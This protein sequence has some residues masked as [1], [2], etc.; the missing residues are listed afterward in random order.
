M[1]NCTNSA[2]RYSEL[3]REIRYRWRLLK[4]IFSAFVVLLVHIAGAQSY[5]PPVGIPAPPFGIE[6]QLDDYYTRPNPWDAETPGWYYIDQYHPNASDNVTYGTPNAPRRTLPAIIPA[7]SVVEIHGDY[8]WAPTG[9]DVLQ[10]EGTAE[11]P[12]FVVGGPNARVLRKW[13]LK[14]SYTI[15]EQLEFTEQ[16]KITIVYP[17]HHIAIRHSNLHH[18]AGKIGGYGNSDSERVH[19]IVIYQNQIHSQEGW[20]ANPEVDLDNH[21]I[22]ISPY[23]ED[24]WVLDNVAYHNGGSFIQVGDF[25]NPADNQKV[26]RFYIGRNTAYAN[27]QSPIGIKQSSD[28]IISENVLYDNRVIQTNAGTQSGVVFQYGPEYLWIINNVIYDSNSGITAGSNSGGDGEYQF[29]IG[30]LIY[31]LA[32]APGYDYNPNTAWAPAAI[33]LAGGINRYVVNNTMVNVDGGIHCPGSGRVVM[34]GNI[35]ANVRKGY[36]V[37]IEHG[38]T[39]SASEVR[40]NVM[41]QAEESVRIRWGNS[42]VLDVAALESSHPEQAGQNQEVWP[43]FTDTTNAD[44]TLQSGSPAVDTGVLSE[45]YS[46][47]Y[48]RYGRDIARDL[49]GIARPAGDDWDVGAYEFTGVTAIRPQQQPVQHTRVYPNPVTDVLQIHGSAGIQ[50]LRVYDVLG[51]VVYQQS[52]WAGQPVRVGFLAPG[53]YILE[54]QG[55]TGRQHLRFFKR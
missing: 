47:F 45:V 53:M 26:R 54:L 41:Y 33:M 50:S 2:Q 21:G 40:Y 29:I 14:S 15:I 7:G 28:V 30:N 37:F 34:T 43:Q 22:K 39:A 25:A 44:F 51:R 6:E 5:Q 17:T 32:V 11:A 38:S 3:P 24:V 31:N 27:R 8:D 48:Q 19:H 46:I 49:N 9:Y 35:V 20:D 23:A 10:A 42:T 4:V 18:M 13:V 12:V 16:G 36:H 1:E 52:R 55:N